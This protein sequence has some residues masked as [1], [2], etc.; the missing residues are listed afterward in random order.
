[1]AKLAS[2]SLRFSA[3]AAFKAVVDAGSLNGAA[4][5]L[6]LSQPTL[7]QLLRSLE[8]TL[9]VELVRRT[10]K[11]IEPTAEGR[12]F[13]SYCCRTLENAEAFERQLRGLHERTSEVWAGIETVLGEHLLS[14][15]LSA[16]RERYSSSQLHLTIDHT[17]EIVDG[18]R[19]GSLN[20]G[21]VPDREEGAHLHWTHL[22]DQPVV[23]ICHPQHPLA[24]RSVV[25]PEELLEHPYVAREPW[26]K[27]RQLN[28]RALES[29]GLSHDDLQVVAEMKTFAG[30]KSAVMM[31]IGFS[32]S[33]WCGVWREVEE[34]SLAAPPLAGRG[35]SYPV[36]LVERAA[37]SMS[38]GHADLRDF[39]LAVEWPCLRAI[40][41]RYLGGESAPAHPTGEA[42]P[43]EAFV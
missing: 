5:L 20:L 1:M 22:L 21:V 13:Y 35:L 36:Y 19:K 28:Q 31:N 38:A 4:N 2:A 41:S 27:C 42:G 33:P 9:A 30:K 37:G 8:T 16:F 24:S 26:T 10:T 14:P 17:H 40:P 25:R 34:G 11:G 3:L 15:V 23:L 12:L 39:L 6:F 7:S 18:V 29:I 32:L 43:A